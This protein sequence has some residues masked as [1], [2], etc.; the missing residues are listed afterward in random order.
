MTDIYDNGDNVYIL[1]LTNRYDALD[2]ALKER[3]DL[4]NT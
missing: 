1:G 3:K 4:V 2:T